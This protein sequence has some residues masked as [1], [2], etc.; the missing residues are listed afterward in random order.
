MSTPSRNIICT[1]EEKSQALRRERLRETWDDRLLYEGI[2]EAEDRKLRREQVKTEWG[3]WL[4]K[5]GEWDWW[6]SLTFRDIEAQGTW[7]RLGWQYT[8]RA[9]REWITELEQRYFEQ[10]PLNRCLDSIGWVRCR[11]EQKGR[12]IDHFHALLSGVGELRRDEAWSWW[13]DRYGMA[14]IEPYDRNK[15]AGYYLCKYVTKE[16]GDIQFSGLTKK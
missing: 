11:E 2:R 5:L 3:D 1:E 13:F 16:L 6:V 4:S 7:T 14:R 12:G 15:G 9:W 10:A 8:G